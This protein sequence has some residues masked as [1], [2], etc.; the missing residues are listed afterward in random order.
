MNPTS[1]SAKFGTLEAQMRL[2]ATSKI[3]LYSVHK[4][5]GHLRLT[6][7][8]KWPQ[9]LL[10]IPMDTKSNVTFIDF[11]LPH[12]KVAWNWWNFKSFC[13]R[14]Q[15]DNSANWR[16][17]PVLKLP[18]RQNNFSITSMFIVCTQIVIKQSSRPPNPFCYSQTSQIPSVFI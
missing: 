3:P 16:P 18:I 9:T 15:I 4:C 1:H 12:N 6:Q 5:W 10:V 14:L 17:F 8:S 13:I 2:K 7:N 11:G